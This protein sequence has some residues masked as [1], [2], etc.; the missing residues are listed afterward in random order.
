MKL[1]V[2]IFRVYIT[3]FPQNA[4]P[5]AEKKSSEAY[6]GDERNFIMA[7][8]QFG[9]EEQ[10]KFRRKHLEKK[11]CKREYNNNLKVPGSSK[12]MEGDKRVKADGQILQLLKLR[13]ISVV[14]WTAA[15]DDC[16]GATRWGISGRVS[17]TLAGCCLV[18][19]SGE[20]WSL[21][22]PETTRAARWIQP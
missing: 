18:A 7:K 20:I 11:K 13:Q 9:R 5:R 4:R 2:T 14:S 17:G 3:P 21:R 10:H 22:L 19:A 15:V 8:L 12:G 1:R 16:R 6:E